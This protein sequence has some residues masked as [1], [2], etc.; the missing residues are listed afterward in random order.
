MWKFAA[1]CQFLFVFDEAFGMSGF[2]TEALEA[3]FENN[4]SNVVPDLIKR[5]L[6][7]LTLD[8]NIDLDNWHHHLRVQYDL[9]D[10]DSNNRFGTSEQPVAW[11]QLSL[12]DKIATLHDLCEWQLM[13]P[14]RFRKL[15]KSEEDVTTWRVSPIGWDAHD[16]AYWL[17][18]DNRIWIQ[19]PQPQPKPQAKPRAPAKKGS[20]RARMEAA[21]ARRAA[22]TATTATKPSP[23]SRS[24][25]NKRSRPSEGTSTSTPS[26]RTRS[27]V[28]DSATSTPSRPPP[29][30]GTRTSAR[31]AAQED[32]SS[33]TPSNGRTVPSPAAAYSSD[34]ELSEPPE[35]VED[36]D[37]DD[38]DDK[39]DAN[40]ADE[41]VKMEDVG[42][43]D[44]QETKADESEAHEDEE[45]DGKAVVK[46][47][48]AE[49]DWV[50]FETIVVTRQEWLDFCQALCQIQGPQREELASVHQ[51]R[52]SRADP[53]CA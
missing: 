29:R 23:A 24:N 33:S 4:E 15:V 38:V 20:K 14:E 9:R 50:E 37:D 28:N 39:A 13:D 5:L 35:T 18:D 36:G 1:V 2:E 27:S 11:A 19:R 25:G 16:N 42:A 3:D 10:V 44:A 22:S 34:S 8:R 48:D 53:R 30:R 46:E 12:E 47:A 7:T 31:F 41:D 6:Y 21:A 45:E 17:F 43:D 51:Q 26:K 52:D 40:G 49:E 32:E